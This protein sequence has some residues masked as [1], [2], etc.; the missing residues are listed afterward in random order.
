MKIL[1]SCIPFDH[2]R[3]GISVYMRNALTALAEAGHELTLVV[4]A[5]AA[6]E[7]VFAR[8]PKIVAPRLARKPVVSMLWHLFCLPFRIRRKRFDLFYLAAANRRALAFR[9]VPTVA[10]V[11]DLA[12]HRVAKKYDGFRMFYQTR[13]LP[14]FIRRAE[15]PTARKDH[16]EL[17]R[18]VASL[19]ASGRRLARAER[20]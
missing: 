1:F 7:P 3:S 10:V 5:E 4:E 13:I 17:E 14:F 8:F 6:D 18:T 16:R 11:H 19:R 12:A 2:G 20:T 15:F 9:P